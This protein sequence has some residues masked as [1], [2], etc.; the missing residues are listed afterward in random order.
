[1]GAADEEDNQIQHEDPIQQTQG[2]AEGETPSAEGEGGRKLGLS[3]KHTI[4]I[5]VMAGLGPVI[6]V[7]ALPAAPVVDAW[8]PGTSP[9]LSG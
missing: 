1:M 8:M 3:L 7:F 2:E 4:H 9:L 5:I 6:Y